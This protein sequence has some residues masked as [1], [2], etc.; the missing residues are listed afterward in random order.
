MSREE[1]AAAVARDFKSAGGLVT[2]SLRGLGNRRG[3][4]LVASANRRGYRATGLP[5]SDRGGGYL[6]GE[7]GCW[8]PGYWLR[9]PEALR[10]GHGL[11]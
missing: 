10:R 1:V 2:A 11:R 4:A 9:R 5:A 3:G 7:R 6:R 8:G